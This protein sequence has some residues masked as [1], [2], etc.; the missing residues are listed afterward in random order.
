MKKP[1]YYLA[2]FGKPELPDKD[3]ADSGS[4]Y[5]GKRGTDTPGERGDIMLLFCTAS[6]AEYFMSS[7]GIGILLTKTKEYIFYRYLPFSSPLSK[8]Q[9]G[10]LFTDVDRNI[11]TS[12]KSNTYWLYDIS[13]ESF[14][15]S[16]RGVLINWP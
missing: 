15:N 1:N 7:P 4:L 5:L 2:V 3:T 13:N 9:L 16:T 12:I 10:I 11:L 14:F 6:D 8:D